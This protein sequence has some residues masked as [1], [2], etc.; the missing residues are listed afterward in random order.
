MAAQNQHY[1]PKFVL[2]HFLYDNESERVCVYD[3]H[4]EKTFITSIKNVMAERRFNDFV[5]DD[6]WIASFEPVACSAEDQVFPAYMQVVQKRR[7]DDTPEQKA[8]L[9]V[10]IAFQ[11]LRTK[12]SRD[13]WQ[14]ME[15]AMVEMVEASGGKVQDMQGWED[16]HPRNE[17]ALKRDHLASIQGSL[18]EFARIIAE[19]DF[20]LAAPT[21]GR[22]FYLGD[23]P[24]CL[25]NS[26]DF[27]PYGNLG[28]AVPG[29][30]IYTPLAA[31]LMLCAWCPSILDDI[32]QSHAV[33]KQA[34]R[35]D[36]LMRVANGEIS[37]ADMKLKMEALTMHE[38]PR[39]EL[40]AAAAEGFP[41]SSSSENMDY[42]NSLQTSF[43]ARY[44]IS[45]EGDF[46]LAR[47]FNGE[48]P[49]LKRGH[50]ITVA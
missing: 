20:V 9:A 43:A 41:V 34:K 24:V 1:V 21:Q 33:A 48:N 46:S 8:A 39:D 40:L 13:K 27:G 2:R 44:V 23:N 11:F 30:E 7:L 49:A 42:Y 31:D 18:G 17:D 19:K 45:R 47:R 50:R 6:D 37:T 28:L 12:A 36:A 38:Q 32:R 29:I 3:K 14:D 22:S 5:F 4:T 10:F 26:R 15:D 35:I 16:W 25:S